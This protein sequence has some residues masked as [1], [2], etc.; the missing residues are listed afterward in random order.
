M[1]SAKSNSQQ[2]HAGG[3]DLYIGGA[4]HAVLHL[5]YARFWHKILFDLGEVST[6]EPFGRLFHQGMITSFAFQR[7]DKSL[8]PVDQVQERGDGQ[9]F[10]IA[11][12]QPVT[13]IVAKMSKSLKNVINPDDVIAQ[14]G[15]DT[16][17]LYEMYMGPLEASKPWNPRDIEGP[18]RFLQRVWRLAVDEQTGQLKSADEP[19]S[20]IEQQLHRTIA[21]VSDDI[22]RLSFNTAIAAMIEFTNLA[23]KS[24]P[25]TSGQ[26]SRLAVALA[27]FA[28]HLAEELWSKLGHERTLAYEAWPTVD[29]TMLQDDQIEMPVQI[30]GKVRG[31]ITVPAGADAKAVEAAA[32]A[33][34]RIIQMIE[35]K[36]I[37]KVVVVPGKI[38]NI[39]AN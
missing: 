11:T 33:D 20:E 10:E 28:P 34:P 24:G 19:D 37:R 13:Q 18:F 30:S 36:T 6:P 23:T 14:Y 35:G 32:L 7:A 12:N 25:L 21:K 39:V 16:F 17:R 26:L 8:L 4:E 29:E 5:L 1:V 15:A 2:P 27:P 22:E 9:Y 31:K 38:V 3:V